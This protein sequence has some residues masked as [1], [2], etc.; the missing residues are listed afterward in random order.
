MLKNISMKN[1]LLLIRKG[2][3]IDIR[4]PLQNRLGYINLTC[5]VNIRK[6][7]AIIQLN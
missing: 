3:L 1:E 5:D 6:R 4:V 2:K 7:L